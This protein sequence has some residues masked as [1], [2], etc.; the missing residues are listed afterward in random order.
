MPWEKL[1]LSAKPVKYCFGRKEQTEK[2]KCESDEAPSLGGKIRRLISFSINSDLS[3]TQFD[4]N[5]NLFPCRKNATSSRIELISITAADKSSKIRHVGVHADM[6][7]SSS[8]PC[9]TSGKRIREGKKLLE[10]VEISQADSAAI[11]YDRYEARTRRTLSSFIK[12]N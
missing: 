1:S 8:S 9:D 5:S 12:F 7:H 10:S 11:I 3:E 2:F 4:I 6:V